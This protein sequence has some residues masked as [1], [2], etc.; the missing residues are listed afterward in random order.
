MVEDKNPKDNNGVT[1][2]HLAV[3]YGN[4]D[5]VQIIIDVADEKNPEDNNGLTP[6]DEAYK[7]GHEEIVKM[8]S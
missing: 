6:L 2:L 1:P 8:L 3:I 7:N 5:I 4:E